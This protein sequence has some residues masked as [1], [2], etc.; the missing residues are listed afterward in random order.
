MICKNQASYKGAIILRLYYLEINL[1]LLKLHIA[2][3]GVQEKANIRDA[4]IADLQ[5]NSAYNQFLIG[6]GEGAW[7]NLK[8][9][10]EAIADPIGTLRG[11][12]EAGKT[13]GSLGLELAQMSETE[14]LQL[15]AQLGKA[16][17][18][19]LGEMTLP[20]ASRHIG[21]FVG[22]LAVDAALGK[23]IGTAITLLKDLKIG[24]KII[25]ETVALSKTV[26]QTLGNVKV[27]V[28]NSKVI[29]DAAGNKWWMPDVEVKKLEDLIK[30]MESRAKENLSGVKKA[31]NL[32]AWNKLSFKLENDGKTIHLI[33][34]HTVT[35]QGY[36]QSISMGGRKD[37]FPANMSEKQIFKAV[38]E[39]YESSKKVETQHLFGEKRVR[40]VGNS[41]D[42]T[43]EMWINLTDNILETAYPIK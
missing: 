19:G 34:N 1:N 37:V 5:N 14:R 30:P 25:S 39:A 9:T 42:L 11:I 24:T 43:I 16:G 2:Y 4:Q 6:V 27:P 41:K 21:N 33:N 10:G 29:V 28:P 12:Y 8:D 17:L 23:G 32:P 15:Y 18:K 36:Q 40:L 35:G 22:A 20:E 38:R 31:I 7:N 13:A 26:K 3:V